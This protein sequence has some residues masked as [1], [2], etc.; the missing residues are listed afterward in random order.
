MDIIDHYF[1]TKEH[2]WVDVDG[3][4]ATVGITDYAQGA[5]G[6]I[7]Y[8][9]M[10]TEDTSLEQFEQLASLESVKSASDIYCPMSGRIVEVNVEL[11]D[12]PGLINREPY[13]KGWI[14]KVEIV[15]ENETSN[16]L[17][18]GEY[19]QYLETLDHSNSASLS[20]LDE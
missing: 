17:T 14:A 6:D 1:Y 3:N 8:I 4:M 13:E 12:D 11:Q 16:L 18:A 19:R 10:P 5:L 20:D 15:N 9:E 7:T 2:E